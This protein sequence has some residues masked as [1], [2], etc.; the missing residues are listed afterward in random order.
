MSWNKTFRK[1]YWDL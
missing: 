1:Y